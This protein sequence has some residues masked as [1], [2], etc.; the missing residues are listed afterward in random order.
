MKAILKFNLPEDMYDHEMCLNG[1]RYHTALY[2][3]DQLLRQ[4]IKYGEFPDEIYEVYE[5]IRE[6]LRDIINNNNVNLD[7]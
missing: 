2:E 4:K 1:Y 3:F 7:V 5:K 6:E